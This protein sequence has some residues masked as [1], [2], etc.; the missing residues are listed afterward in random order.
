MI[1]LHVEGAHHLLGVGERRRVDHRDVE[2]RGR[3]LG[4]PAHDVRAHEPVRV[5]VEPVLAEV[6]ARPVEVGLREID[7]GRA[8]RAARRRVHA[9]GPRVREQVQDVLAAARLTHHRAHGSVV[10]E[11]PGVEVVV[12]V[13]Q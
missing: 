11:E 9:E 12:E 3:R 2:A 1:A 6:V 10:Q 4:D 5:A 13:H 7:R 8:P